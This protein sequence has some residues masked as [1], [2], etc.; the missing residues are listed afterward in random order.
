MKMKIARWQTCCYYFFHSVF[1]YL[2]TTRHFSVTLCLTRLQNILEVHQSDIEM[3]YI[4]QQEN[5]REYHYSENGFSPSWKFSICGLYILIILNLWHKL[6]HLLLSKDTCYI[7]STWLVWYFKYK[8]NTYAISSIHQVSI[9]NSINE[10]LWFHR[11]KKDINYLLYYNK[12][13]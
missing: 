3:T 12:A 4:Y 13:Y 11:S 8:T 2:F 9:S 7:I 5:T 1:Y 10:P 6:M